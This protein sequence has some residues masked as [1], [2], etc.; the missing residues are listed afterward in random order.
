MTPPTVT[1]STVPS[2]RVVPVPASIDPTGRVD[3]TK[4]MQRF[5]ASVPSGRDISFRK[6]AHYRI[7]GTL[8]IR[9]RKRITIDGNGA[10]V[11]ARTRGG[12]ARSQWW[13]KGGTRIIFRNLIV[14]GA[15]PNAG[16]G[17]DAYVRKLETQHGFRFEG[18]NGAE[19]D[20]VQVHDVYGDFVYIGRGRDRVPSRDVW[21][22]DSRFSRNGRQGISV[23]AASNVVIERNHLDQTRRST[24]DLEPDARSALVS[25]VF[26]LNNTVG[27]GHLLFLASHGRGPVD[28]VVVSGNQL[29]GHSLTPSTPYRRGT[30]RLLRSVIVNN[31]SDTPAPQRPLRFFGIDGL[32]VRGNR[33]LV[34]GDQPGVVLNGVCGAH[35]SGNQFG[36]GGTRQDTPQCN[37]PLTVPKLPAIAGRRTTR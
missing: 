25:N 11:F 33:Q 22:H 6:G 24:I 28:N 17:D 10:T 8:F 31:V 15:N 27:K 12:P 21:V 37:A 1:P 13:I 5:L 16:T 2:R 23:T 26:I 3:V 36:S 20:H 19:L 32:V 7:E 14:R 18:V 9:H 30:A 35:V 29:L 34:T 4:S